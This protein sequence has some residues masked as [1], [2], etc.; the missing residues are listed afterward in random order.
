MTTKQS[1]R[2]MRRERR[3][4]DAIAR[5]PI[6]M[7]TA[8][9]VKATESHTEGCSIANGNDFG[10]SRCSECSQYHLF[11]DFD[12]DKTQHYNTSKQC[13]VCNDTYRQGCAY[14]P[15]PTVIQHMVGGL[16]CR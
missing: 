12:V 11:E 3:Y 9:V 14:I 8:F 7:R 1:K 4:N 5:Y 15:L 6:D 10:V 2:E 16:V 13:T